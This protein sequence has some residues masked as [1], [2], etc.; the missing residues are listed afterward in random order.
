MTG[1]S[2]CS[3]RRR[4]TRS[5]DPVFLADLS[6]C[7]FH[8]PVARA[9][10]EPGQHHRRV[11]FRQ[12]DDVSRARPD[13]MGHG[14]CCYRRDGR[15]CAAG[16]SRKSPRTSGSSTN[17]IVLEDLQALPRDRWISVRYEQLLADPAKATRRLCEFAGIQFDTALS[18]RVAGAL[19]LA[20]Y[21]HTP[22]DPDKWRRHETAI[23]RVL[24]LVDETRQRLLD[25]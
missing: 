16:R 17:R 3:R 19:P 5:A 6:R 8:L 4:R 12:L 18:E 20:R 23:K 9:A 10:R 14:R 25:L 15:H 2:G 13:G 22:P 7:P 11:A 24:P 21:T 1:Y